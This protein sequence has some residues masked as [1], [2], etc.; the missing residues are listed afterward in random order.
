MLF[1][2]MGMAQQEKQSLPSDTTV[3]IKGRKY[4]IHEADQTLNVKVFGKGEKGDTIANDMVYEA[5]YND[6]QT[7]ERRFEFSTPFSRLKNKNRKPQFTDHG[8]L[9]L[10]YG[11]LKDGF[12]SGNDAADLQGAYSWEIGF[13]FISSCL[14]LT[15]NGHWG[16]TFNVDWGYRSF[17]LDGNY[18]FLKKDGVTDIYAGTEG[19]EYSKSR[20]RYNFFRI[21]IQLEYQTR[22]S[23]WGEHNKRLAAVSLGIEPEI[24]YRIQSKA[25]V[26]GEKHTLE[27]NMNVNPIGLNAIAKIGCG[28]LAFYARYSMTPLFKDNHGPKMYPTSLGIILFW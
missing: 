18:A 5:T 2:M 24:R 22:F 17:R 26:N 20:I 16:I 3:F 10:G 28:D 25:K 6:E 11:N 23:I 19:T 15:Y 4:V 8:G 14:P 12:L 13:S 9:F 7:T 21:P 1:P 27:K